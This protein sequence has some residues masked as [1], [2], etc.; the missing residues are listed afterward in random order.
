M[1]SLRTGLAG[2][3]GPAMAGFKGVVAAS[4]RVGAWSSRR[5][6]E[7]W[8]RRVLFLVVSV[9]LCH[10]G[11][12]VATSA[13]PGQAETDHYRAEASLDVAPWQTSRLR[14]FTTVGDT[15]IDFRS[16]FPAPGIEARPQVKMSLLDSV[17]AESAAATPR[18]VLVPSTGEVDQAARV[19]V[20]SLAV[21]YLL[22]ALL[23][24]LVLIGAQALHGRKWRLRQ[25]LAPLSAVLLAAALTGA[26]CAYVYRPDRVASYKSTE[27]LAAVQASPAV[28]SQIEERAGQVGPYITNWL[29]LQRTLQDR[30]V[31]SETT[32]ADS[33]RFL[34]ISDV[35]GTNEYAVVK[36]IIQ[37]ENISAV[38]DSGDLI[39][40]GQVEE[41]EL[42][43]VF[44]G[45]Q[46]LGVPYLFV[47]GNH[48]AAST[49]DHRLL[50]RMAEIPNVY[51]LQPNDTTY[52]VV[53]I[54]GV[55]VAGLNDPRYYGDDNDPGR[56]EPP[57]ALNFDASMKGVPDLDLAVAHEPT[58]AEVITAGRL[59][60]NG[61]MHVAALADRR[62][63][64]GT[65][66]GGGLMSHY[67]NSLP[68][69]GELGGQ[70]QAFDILRFNADCTVNSLQRFVFSDLI[71]GSPKYDSISVVNGPTLKAPIPSPGRSCTLEGTPLVERVQARTVPGG[72]AVGSAG[73][74]ST[75]D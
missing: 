57:A 9:I 8:L 39:N 28:L 31:T 3:T 75:R 41:G 70:P 69:D 46:S 22:G 54:G 1:P 62:I 27:L 30:F 43:G 66:T 63:Q 20:R 60:I 49:T 13:F 45:I 25:V 21:R 58:A 72:T 2:L 36:K 7:R 51:L 26:S 35:H 74:R 61:H 4:G 19:L 44:K 29:T 33:V 48:D 64:V 68:E 73:Q 38:I 5:G 16:K 53:S 65:L 42:A 50:D 37:E 34:L 11:G 14:A 47:D 52:D 32:L 40:F 10:L 59:R 23:V 15:T 17:A 24:A 12:A 55:R 56:D 6:V 18:Q 71:E 67:R